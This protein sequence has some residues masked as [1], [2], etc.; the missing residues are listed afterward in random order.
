VE[1]V[2]EEARTLLARAARLTPNSPEPLQVRCC[3]AA[4][5]VCNALIAALGQP[6]ALAGLLAEQGHADE[7]LALLHQSLALWLP[8]AAEDADGM[9]LT[10]VSVGVCTTLTFT[11]NAALEALFNV[12][13][14]RPVVYDVVVPACAART[15]NS[16]N[17]TFIVNNGTF[18]DYAAFSQADCTGLLTLFAAE[19]AAMA[20]LVEA[21]F[22][23]FTVCSDRDNCNAPP[24]SA[25]APRGAA[26]APRQSSPVLRGGRARCL[27]AARSSAPGGTRLH[28]RAA[29]AEAR[30]GRRRRCAAHPLA[31]GARRASRGKA[32]PQTAGEQARRQDAGLC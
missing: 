26:T 8:P 24:G 12:A 4:L 22:Q 7:A 32:V 25:A 27:S 6:Q 23:G 20:S 19:E 1:T 31:A 14:L 29:A 2:A 5:C 21:A 28:K 17:A 15:G 16:S 3:A 13:A 9:N 18:T 30:R 10:D 11:C